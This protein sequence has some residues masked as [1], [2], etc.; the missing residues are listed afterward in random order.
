MVSHVFSNQSRSDKF[1]CVLVRNLKP[2]L[3]LHCH[4]DLHV[5]QRVQAEV[6]D[7]VT[8]QGQ[9]VRGNLIDLKVKQEDSPIRVTLS[10]A[11]QTLRTLASISAVARVVEENLLTLKSLQAGCWGWVGI[12]KAEPD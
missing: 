7:E 12:L 11:L 9:L 1:L 4:D 8:L 2:K 6:I 3:V 10:K 5:V